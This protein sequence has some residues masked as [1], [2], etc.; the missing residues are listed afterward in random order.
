[1]GVVQ[2][3]CIRC[4]SAVGFP[5]D[6]PFNDEVTESR[7]EVLEC[8]FR[9]LRPWISL[10]L[11]MRT[12][13]LAMVLICL[14]IIKCYLC[15]LFLISP[16]SLLAELQQNLFIFQ[17]HIP[18]LIFLKNSLPYLS[19]Y[20]FLYK[21]LGKFSCWIGKGLPGFDSVATLTED[22]CFF[23]SSS[24]QSPILNNLNVSSFP[25]RTTGRDFPMCVHLIDLS[26]V[27][28]YERISVPVR[29]A[30]W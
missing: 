15:H 9:N 7:P 1:M 11:V 21:R 19:A 4:G 26:L 17:V 6:S 18:A 25:L 29:N 16:R 23:R 5:S 13:V 12:C 27:R 24:F 14:S 2:G 22:V 8:S 28:T 30:I 3:T 20:D 10:K